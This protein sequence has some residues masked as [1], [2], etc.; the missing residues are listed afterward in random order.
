MA[1]KKFE[2]M[3]THKQLTRSFRVIELLMKSPETTAYL[4][5]YLHMDQTSVLRYIRE[6]KKVGFKIERTG[7][8]KY[9]IVECPFCNC[10]N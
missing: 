4:A 10:R 2:V 9:Q 1:L 6:L 3:E 5:A 8:F 7:G